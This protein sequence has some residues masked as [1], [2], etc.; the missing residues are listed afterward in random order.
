MHGHLQ[1]R[2]LPKTCALL[3]AWQ[4]GF[5]CACTCAKIQN[6]DCGSTDLVMAP[7]ETD[8]TL[9]KTL[10]P[11]VIVSTSP[12]GHDSRVEEVHLKYRCDKAGEVSAHVHLC[13]S[14]CVAVCAWTLQVRSE[15]SFPFSATCSPSRTRFRGFTKFA[16]C[17]T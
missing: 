6:H 8:S 3:S 13:L 16:T 12:N 11:K 7:H 9:H 17:E 4:M 15:P 2:Y 14:A 5:C 1:I 10:N